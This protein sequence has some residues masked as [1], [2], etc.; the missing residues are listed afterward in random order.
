MVYELTHVQ[1]HSCFVLIKKQLFGLDIFE[2]VFGE[3]SKAFQ[4]Y[5]ETEF[6]DFQ[7]SVLGHDCYFV[8][9]DCYN[10]E[11]PFEKYI[12]EYMLKDCMDCLDDEEL[13]IEYDKA[14]DRLEEQLAEVRR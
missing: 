10:D 7:K 12:R 1:E 2:E 6:A 14:N 13:D 5:V 4:D 3:D 9:Y 8:A 11:D